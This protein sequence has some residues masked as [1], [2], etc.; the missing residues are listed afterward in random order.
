KVMCNTNLRGANMINGD[1]FEVDDVIADANIMNI[2]KEVRT[3]TEPEAVGVKHRADGLDFGWTIT[4]HKYQGCE[5]DVVVFVI[6]KSFGGF[7]NRNMVYT[8]ITRAKKK[9][10]IIGDKQAFHEALLTE[11]RE[12]LTVLNILTRPGLENAIEHGC[13]VG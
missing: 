10:I 9:V 2:I 7:V 4:V 8:A 12:R 5:T 3:P 6:S 11:E 1:M 13:V